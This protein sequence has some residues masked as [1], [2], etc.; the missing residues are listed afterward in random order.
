MMNRDDLLS[1]LIRTVV[2][3]A[4][5]LVGASLVGPF[6]DLK[7]LDQALSGIISVVYYTVVRFAEAKHPAASLFLGSRKV[8]IYFDSKV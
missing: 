6:V 5:G 7:S 1:S 3:I 8:P 2:P 4:V